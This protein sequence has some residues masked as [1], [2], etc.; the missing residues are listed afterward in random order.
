MG[1]RNALDDVLALYLLAASEPFKK[2]QVAEILRKTLPDEVHSAIISAQ[3]N[4]STDFEIE[5]GAGQGDWARCPWVAIRDPEMTDSVQRGYYPVYLFRED[6]SG[7]YLSLN[8]GVTDIR[9]QYKSENKQALKSR[10]SDYRSRLGGTSERFPEASIDL[11]P[12]SKQNYS[13]DYEAGNVVA[14]YYD[15]AALPS[16]QNLRDDL[17]GMLALYESLIYSLGSEVGIGI[18]PEE[19]DNEF[20]EDYA[21]FRYHRRIERNPALTKEVKKVRGLTC[22]ACGL[23]FSK[24]YPLIKKNKYIEAHHLVPIASL[25]G[26]RVSR[27]PN[28]DFA[29]LCANCHRMIHRFDAP[30]DLEAFRR[31]INLKLPFG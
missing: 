27:D 3:L 4:L 25:K 15:A 2:N 17:F 29:V 9:E 5:G 7:V 22:E 31:V 24:T 18:E 26:Q 30:W 8:Q 16:E 11:K 13:A 28:K 19:R 12:S 21:A 10:A 20:I 23:N 1:L 6:M 14:K